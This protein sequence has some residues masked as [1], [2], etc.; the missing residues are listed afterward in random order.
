[1]ASSLRMHH[2]SPA[3]FIDGKPVFMGYLWTGT[4]SVGEW[5][6][7]GPVAR[8]FCEAGVH[9]YAFDVGGTE[10]IGPGPGRSGH[11]DLSGVEA[12]FANV[13]SFDPGAR[14]HLRV[15]LEQQKWWWD[16]YPGEC[17]RMSTGE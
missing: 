15:G 16:L 4:P 3:L 9:L 6:D 7:N 8:K 12:R 10:W 5:L 14:F 11:V 2:G 17:E 1:M 13:L